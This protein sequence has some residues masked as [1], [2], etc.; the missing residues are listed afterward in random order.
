[1]RTSIIPAVNLNQ[2]SEFSLVILSLGV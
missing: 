1:L 2:I